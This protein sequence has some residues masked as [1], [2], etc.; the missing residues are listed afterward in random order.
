MIAAVTKEQMDYSTVGERTAMPN[1]LSMRQP[2][3]LD[4]ASMCLYRAAGEFIGINRIVDEQEPSPLSRSR[5]ITS[6]S[7]SFSLSSA[8]PADPYAERDEIGAHGGRGLR[9]IDQVAR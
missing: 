4:A 1:G 2:E 8:N 5:S 6:A 3:N 7:T 9:R